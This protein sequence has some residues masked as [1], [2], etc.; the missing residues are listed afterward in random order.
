MGY[1]A[2]T[3]E[4]LEKSQEPVRA[5]VIHSHVT[6][7]VTQ[8]TAIH[9]TKVMPSDTLYDIVDLSRVW[10]MADIY[11]INAN[12]VKVGTPV[13]IELPYQTNK[14]ITGKFS[15]ID[16]VVDP[17]TRTIKARVE[18]PNPSNDLKPNM[19]ANGFCGFSR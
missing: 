12:S 2:R 18:V 10:I 3:I 7:F 15:Y 5:L 13:T 19:Y 17:Q 1:W 16:P 9:G 6:G 11:E 14:I 8:K 4:K